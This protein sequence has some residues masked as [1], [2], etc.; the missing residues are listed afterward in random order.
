M[1]DIDEKKLIATQ[2]NRLAVAKY[3]L[4]LEEK[5]LVLLLTSLVEP[6]DQDFKDY[7]IKISDVQRILGLSHKGIYS[8]IKKVADSLMRRVITIEEKNGGWLKLNWVSSSRYIP[9]G[10][11]GLEFACLDLSFDPKLKPYLLELK[12]QFYSFPL[13]SI[14]QLRSLYSIRLYEILSSHKRYGHATF[15]L[16]YLRVR[17]ELEN[18]YKNFKDFRVYI[19]EKSKKELTEKSDLYFDYT[20]IKR[21]RKVAKIDFKIYTKKL[22]NQPKDEPPNPFENP[23]QLIEVPE[24]NNK[25]PKKQEIVMVN[26]AN[27]GAKLTPITSNQSQPS[28]P[29]NTASSPVQERLKPKGGYLLLRK[30]LER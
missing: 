29:Q 22:P 23:P 25:P 28:P 2:D 10:T 30:S 1:H 19:L 20:P 24:Q 7:R 27:G 5:R 16:A 14:V 21:G 8:R 3:T 4:S 13:R 12:E 18:K 26:F 11:N 9:K 6:H 15:E 17:L